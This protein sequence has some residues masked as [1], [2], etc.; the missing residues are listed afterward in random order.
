MTTKAHVIAM[1]VVAIMTVGSFALL[2]LASPAKATQH[3][4]EKNIVKIGSG[5]NG[6]H[7]GDGGD[8]GNAVFCKKCEGGDGGDGGDANGGNGGEHNGHNLIVLRD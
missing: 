6:G 8:G 7:G 4:S 1:A 2:G 3:D 5:G